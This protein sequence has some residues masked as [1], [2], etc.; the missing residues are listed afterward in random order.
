MAR[1][2]SSQSTFS[3]VMK[4]EDSNQVT[5][6]VKKFALAKV[7]KIDSGGQSAKT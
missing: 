1:F 3:A 5:S 7:L 4:A 6:Y 2:V